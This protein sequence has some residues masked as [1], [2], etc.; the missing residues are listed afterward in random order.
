[1]LCFLVF[2]VPNSFYSV[3]FRMQ[4]TV[5]PSIVSDLTCLVSQDQLHL[6]LLFT[7]GMTLCGVYVRN[8]HRA[9]NLFLQGYEKSWIEAEEPYFEDKLI[10]DLAVSLLKN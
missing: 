5:I 7:S 4:S 6:K 9:V 8:R 2:I 3:M 10:D 1:M